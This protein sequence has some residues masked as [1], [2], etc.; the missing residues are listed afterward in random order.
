MR[1]RQKERQ[2]DRARERERHRQSVDEIRTPFLRTR[3]QHFIGV[4]FF[5]DEAL[6]VFRVRIAIVPSVLE[7]KTSE[8]VQ[9]FSNISQFHSDLHTIVYLFTFIA[10]P[11]PSICL[12]DWT[13]HNLAQREH[14]TLHL[15]SSVVSLMTQEK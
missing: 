12:V 13:I 2:I 10:G 15:P 9:R 6:F 1:C 3:F 5:F 8:R 14:V 11:C 7:K 4:F